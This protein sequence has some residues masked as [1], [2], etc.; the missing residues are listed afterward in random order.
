MYPEDHFS[1]EIPR[2][3]IKDFQGELEVLSADIKV[4]NESLEV[5]Y[6]YMDPKEVENSVAIWISGGVTSSAVGQTQL[7]INKREQGKNCM[8]CFSLIL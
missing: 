4:R 8:H 1:E 6:T 2:K 7:H 5:P 3:L